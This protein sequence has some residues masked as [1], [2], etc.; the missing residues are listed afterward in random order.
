MILSAM[1][2][3]LEDN[4]DSRTGADPASLSTPSVSVAGGFSDETSGLVEGAQVA[5]CFACSARDL[6]GFGRTSGASRC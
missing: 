1:Y 3:D 2:Q 5:G 4:G 6:F